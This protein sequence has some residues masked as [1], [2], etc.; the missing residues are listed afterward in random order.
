MLKKKPVLLGMSDSEL[1]S[2]DSAELERITRRLKVVPWPVV[3]GNE[4]HTCGI[5]EEALGLTAYIAGW[6][7]RGYY[8][9][10]DRKPSDAVQFIKTIN[11]MRVMR[12]QAT[13]DIRASGYTVIRDAACWFVTEQRYKLLMKHCSLTFKEEVF[14]H[15]IKK[16]IDQC[17][18]NGQTPTHVSGTETSH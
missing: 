10:T 9:R 15:E 12:V 1:F 14:E 3:D 11:W 16:A 5:D 8:V 13:F 7:D 4:V 2:I 18:R 6:C 17:K